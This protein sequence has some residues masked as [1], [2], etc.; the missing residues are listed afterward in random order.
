MDIVLFFI[1]LMQLGSIW[2]RSSRLRLSVP[3]WFH[4][5]RTVCNKEHQLFGTYLLSWFSGAC[6]MT[7][8]TLTFGSE[9]YT[10][11]CSCTT[12]FSNLTCIMDFWLYH[13][14]MELDLYCDFLEFNLYYDFLELLQI[15]YTSWKFT[16][17]L[18]QLTTNQ[19]ITISFSV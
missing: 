7:F 17:S 4:H 6:T 9:N 3:V 1:Y 10:T 5:I 15:I 19:P 18:T 8:K 14:F 13:A 2:N 12:T 11:F 16:I